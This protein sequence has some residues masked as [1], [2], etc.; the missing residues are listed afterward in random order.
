M[1]KVYQESK[2]SG[3]S[4]PF[5]LGLHRSDY[6]VESD[7][8]GGQ[9][10]LM[11]EINTIASSMGGHA[12]GIGKMHRSIGTCKNENFI[13]NNVI[14]SLSNGIVE[15]VRN[16]A[17]YYS[18]SLSDLCV[19]TLRE[20][21]GSVNFSDQKRIEIQV[22]KM[23]NFEVELFRTTLLDFAQIQAGND[24]SIRHK[25]KEVA[26][27][28]LRTGYDPSC[29]KT[30]AA[31]TAR[32]NIENSRSI[33]SPSIRYHLLTNKVFQAKFTN[34]TILEQFISTDEAKQLLKTF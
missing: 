7:G 8:A 28:Y 24:G 1:F 15:A 11:V 25:N 17:K 22:Q 27:F 34:I 3:F 5:E 19:I 6:L 10:P 4:S 9:I 30:A 23:L 18:K 16:Y 31:W 29:Y 32:Q 33:K 2:K 20:E 14:K 13:K 12:V 21:G 26:V